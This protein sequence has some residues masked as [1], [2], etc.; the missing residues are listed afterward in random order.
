MLPA[1]HH[2]RLTPGLW[3][4][5]LS[6]APPLTRFSALSPL[7]GHHGPTSFT[8]PQ[9]FMYHPTLDFSIIR[10]PLH[11]APGSWLPV[12]SPRALLKQVISKDAGPRSTT[13]SVSDHPHS[14]LLPNTVFATWR[15]LH[16]HICLPLP[17]RLESS[18]RDLVS[19]VADPRGLDPQ[20]LIRVAVS[21]EVDMIQNDD[22]YV[23]W[24]T[25][26]SFLG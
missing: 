16:R 17:L 1:H 18:I 12:A 14:W 15:N 9:K 25:S 2:I 8:V 4:M 6:L 19:S 5:T 20:A 11:R 21:R 24:G 7:L 13:L 26:L 22:S 3:A 23:Y 10:A